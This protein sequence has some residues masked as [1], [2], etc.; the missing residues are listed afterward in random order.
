MHYDNVIFK[1]YNI[2]KTYAEQGFEKEAFDFIISM[3]VL[4]VSYNLE[5]AV[6][7]LSGLLKKNGIFAC[8]QSFHTEI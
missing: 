4:Q 3:D 6:N 5:A 8:V 2:E 1:Q 7:N